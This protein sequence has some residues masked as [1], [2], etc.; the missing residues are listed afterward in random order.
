MKKILI[1]ED[2][3]MVGRILQKK[4]SLQNKYEI[5]QASNGKEGLEQVAK[6]QPDFITT[7]LMM[8]NVNGFEVLAGI[9]TIYKNKT[10]RPYILVLSN[11]SGGDDIKKAKALGANHFFVKSDTKIEAIV[12]H[13][14]KILNL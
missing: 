12:E 2:D 11:I 10:N 1:I 3:I 13:I 8:P 5:F 4:L 6:Y 7:D 9:N 14:N